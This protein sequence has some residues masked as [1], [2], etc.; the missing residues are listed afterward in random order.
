MSNRTPTPTIVIKFI[1]KHV[2]DNFYGL[3]LA[4]V[5]KKPLMSEDIQLAQGSRIIISENL[6]ALNQLIFL[7]AL[8]MKGEKRF[9]RVHTKD[10]LVQIK[11]SVD[12][13]PITIRASHEL[14][15]NANVVQTGPLNAE[16]SVNKDNNRRI[17]PDEMLARQIIEASKNQTKSTNNATVNNEMPQSNQST[18]AT[19]PMDQ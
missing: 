17:H 8:R 1:A 2:R 7:K 18:R 11:K 12:E 16:S 15:L 13:K 19:Q 3:Y 10:G 9:A 5:G 4:K 6:T 14:D